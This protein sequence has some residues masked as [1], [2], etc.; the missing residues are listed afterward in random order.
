MPQYLSP[1]VYVEEVDSGSRPIEGVGTAV[2]AFVGLAAAG[3]V[4]RAHARHQLDPVHPDL[5]R[6]RRGL[7]PG[8]RR[9]RLLHERRRHAYVV[10]IGGEGVGRPPRHAA[11]L[12]S[13][14]R[15]GQGRRRTRCR[16]LEAGRGGNDIT[17]EVSAR[18]SGS[19]EPATRRHVQPR[20]CKQGGKV[21]ETY[22]G[23]TAKRGKQNAVD[24]W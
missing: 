20:S 8:P 3:P 9:L 22:D 7:L 14:S 13:G 18:P 17:V 19:E 16:R 6:L 10:R 1:G 11:E 4:Q 24:A 2:A 12:P 15:Q 5:R 21:E 23:L